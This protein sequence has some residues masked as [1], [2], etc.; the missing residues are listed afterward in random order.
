L[1]D[2]HFDWQTQSGRTS[3]PV[4]DTLYDDWRIPP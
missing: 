3:H 1:D 4:H 2:G